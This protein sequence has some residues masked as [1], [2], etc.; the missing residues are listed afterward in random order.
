MAALRA[1]KVDRGLKVLLTAAGLAM[2]AGFALAAQNAPLASSPAASDPV[3]EA[4][5][6]AFEALAEAD[7]RAVQDGLVWT[8]D[9]NG[10]VDGAFGKRTRDSILSYQASVRAPTTG[11]LDA[12]AIARLVATAQKAKD[13]VKFEIFVDDKTGVKIGAPLK[14]LD[15]R[16]VNGA[17]SRLFKSDGSISL[18]LAAL[19]GGEADLSALYARLSA[20]QPGRKSTLKL[21]RPDFFVLSWEEGGRKVYSRYAKPPAGASDP[22]LIR[23]FTLAYP[24]QSADFERIAVA[25]ANSFEPFPAPSAPQPAA[26]ASPAPAS[27]KAALSANGLF[28]APGKALSAIGSADC[29]HPAIDGKPAKYL[30]E[31]AQSGLSLIGAPAAG[32]TQVAAPTL[33][34]LSNDLVAVTYGFDEAAARPVLSVTPVSPLVQTNSDGKPR[35]LASLGEDAVGGPLFDRK[36]ALV[37]LIARSSSGP[38]SVAGVSPQAPHAVVAAADIE[39]FLSA[40]DVAIGKPAGELTSSAGRIAAE[41]SALVVTIACN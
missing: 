2:W 31:D 6:T 1:R 32:E 26:A 41:K 30:S 40:A 18:D 28:V 9:Y 13:A 34:P 16:S 5:K 25:I 20:D 37:A 29:P 14:I 35:V 19:S 27:A 15:K 36:G 11:I 17:G 12:G 4:Q 21:S 22:N 24:G 33:A 3:F 38:K 8:G 39:R 10:I 7:R 23:G